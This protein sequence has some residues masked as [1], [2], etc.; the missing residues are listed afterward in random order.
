MLVENINFD[1]NLPLT[2]HYRHIR[3]IALIIILMSSCNRSTRTFF[4]E[5]VSTELARYRSRQIYDVSY[6][7]HFTVPES[8]KDPVTG[9]VKITF[10]PLKARHGVILDFTP[11]ESS[12]HQILVNGTT[13]DYFIMHGHIYIDANELVP[14]Q[15]NTIEIS[16]T[17]TNQ[18]L[19]R[20]EN[21]MYS[22]FVPDR[23][24][25]AFPCFDQPDIKASFSLS[26][27]LPSHWSAL[28]NGAETNN[29]E[30]ESTREIAF[31][32]TQPL[33]TYL[34]AFTAG[35]FEILEQTRRERTIRIFHRETDTQK[36]DNNIESIFEQHF[37]SLE[38]LEQYTG[39]PYPYGKFDLAILPGFQYSGMEHP[40]AI[41]YRDTRLLL[42]QDPPLSLVMRKAAL[43]AHETA[44]MWFGDLVTMKWFDDV[45][46][47][48]VFAGFMADKIVAEQFPGHNHTLQFV[49]THY[50]RSLSV[51]RTEGTHPIRQKL[52]N[53]KQAGTLYGPIIYNKAPIV[54]RQLEMIMTPA[55]FQQAVR[56]YL[57]RY[58]HSNADWDQL[59]EILDKYTDRDIK[60]WSH[61]WVYQAGMPHITY[62]H[63]TP[64]TIISTVPSGVVNDFTEQ[65]LGITT[66]N[67][68]MVNHPQVWFHKSPMTVNLSADTSQWVLL[69][70]QG[71]GY[72]YFAMQPQDVER[73]AS[74]QIADETTRA[75]AYMNMFENFLH[76]N[77]NSNTFYRH[78]T[79]ALREETNQML[80]NY[81]LD[82]L[83]VWAFRFPDYSL[84]NDYQHEVNTLLWE[85][86]KNAPPASARLFF[87]SWLKITRV[88]ESAQMIRNIY[89]GKVMP[90]AVVL[91]D[92][93]YTDLAL[94]AWVR[95]SMH[96]DLVEQ[97]MQ[98]ITNPDRLRR[99]HFIMPAAS[100]DRSQRDNF[101]EKMKDPANR[102]PE[103]W[104]TEA[105]Y[106]LHHPLHEDMGLAYVEESLQMLPEIQQTGDIFFPQD[107]LMATLDNYYQTE[108]AGMVKQYLDTTPGLQ[109][110]LR[111]KVLQASDILTR[112]S[113]LQ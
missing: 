38:W 24:S 5:G 18:A 102:N 45:W 70:G 96:V 67:I 51:D 1:S 47:K 27:T 103:P 53:M 43:I 31:A 95:D 41:W 74:L 88:E 46:L 59:V 9:N 112:S 40:G 57:V 3:L 97:E 71:L 39:I 48:E 11:G 56:E 32:A 90:G 99:L 42:E 25:T 87:E 12:V 20:S 16:F 35:E 65:Y 113:Q 93:N 60:S 15:P 106:F 37:S 75:M 85:K 79:R 36:L 64:G 33:S 34:F 61:A 50:P 23:A 68:T 92:Q 72:G 105:L 89:L 76:A 78:L 8:L 109:P 80:Q 77:V 22:L 54:F 13:S 66:G 55:S 83:R 7:L 110:N 21:F 100:P 101:F 84:H 58:Y 82:N 81:L 28:S 91:S 6:Q 98:R 26:L 17:A 52:A 108:V 86:M 94:E 62:S 69:N 2:M 63:K 111:L 10:K 19:N 30:K 29:R 107:W 4:Q 49:L 73:I 44:H 104:V 14:R